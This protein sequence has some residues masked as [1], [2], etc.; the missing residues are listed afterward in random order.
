MKH[1]LYTSFLLLIL[2]FQNSFCQNPSLEFYS[3]GL[4]SFYAADYESA[5]NSYNRAIEL[6][7]TMIPAYYNRGQCF[8]KLKNIDK[9]I[10]DFKKITALDSGFIDAWYY[11]GKIYLDE[12]M[13]DSAISYLNKSLSLSSNHI[14]SLKYA[15]LYNY[16]KGKFAEAI[17]MYT[18]II[19]LQE[20][21]DEIYYMRALC[22]NQINL[23]APAE[24]DLNYLLQKNPDNSQALLE[25]IDIN[26]KRNLLD[27][28]CEDVNKLKTKAHPGSES[29]YFKYCSK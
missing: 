23:L 10:K 7:S 13:Y 26:I 11:I 14:P 3:D 19:D 24:N 27:K 28:V 17:K 9:S 12:K 21:D 22:L 5:I 2:P 20:A 25:R 16:F 15:G 18:K 1:F 4:R 6:D 8:I 29:L